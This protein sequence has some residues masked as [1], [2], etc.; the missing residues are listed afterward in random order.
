MAGLS[1]TLRCART[2]KLKIS[3]VS[4]GQI[5]V[6]SFHEVPY[7]SFSFFR[8]FLEKLK[9]NYNFISP[10]EFHSFFKGEKEIKG[11]NILLT[12]DD[13]FISAKEAT[14]K[15]LN[16][17]DIKAFFFIPVGFIGIEGDWKE[18][19]L[20]KIFAGLF[21]PDILGPE[22][23]PM[24]WG[25]IEWLLSTGHGI[26]SHTVNH[27]K[28]SSLGN[29]E[30]V[31]ELSKSAEVLKEKLGIYVKD[32]AYPLGGIDCVNADTMKVIKDYYGYC[33]SGVR[34][35]NYMATNSLAI[36]RDEVSFDYFSPHYVEFIVEN[37]L[38]WY[39]KKHVEYLNRIV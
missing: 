30:L 18:F 38:G 25:D 17:L 37:G 15:I 6:L 34:G 29:D 8:A 9:T 10:D 12:F 4:T 23:V 28:L 26:G 14:E 16:P 31:Y 19:A 11:L 27:C 13:G 1:Y 33:F 22:H 2:I 24:T 39:Y 21:P 32:I 36:L 5:K 20:Q 3:G 35:V 7:N